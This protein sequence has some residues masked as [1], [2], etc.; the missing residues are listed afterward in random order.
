MTLEL[1]PV[2]DV[3]EL[4]VANDQLARGYVGMPDVTDA[5]FI[6]PPAAWG[7]P[8]VYRTGDLMRRKPDGTL[9]FIGRSAHQ[10]EV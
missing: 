2:G 1:V 7:E 10:V 9:D 5:K 8:R 4:F 6:A 3:G